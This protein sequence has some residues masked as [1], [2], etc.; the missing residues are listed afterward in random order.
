MILAFSMKNHLY[1]LSAITAIIAVTLLGVI[2]VRAQANTSQNI[3]MSP[4][5]T[6]ISVKAGESI[7]KSFQILNSGSDAYNIVTM[8]SPYRVTGLEYTPQFTQL[9]GTTETT[10]WVKVLDPV[11]AVGSQKS[12][13]ITYTVAVPEGTAP[14]GYYAVL[15]AE[16]RPDTSREDSGVVPRNRVGNIL[17]ITVEGNVQ[18]TGDVEVEP[19]GGFRYQASIPLG[20]KISNT[21][22]VHFQANV[23]ASVKSITGKELYHVTIER[24]VLPQTER[25]IPIEWAPSS[26]VGIYTVNRSANI[27]GKDQTFAEERII[28]IQP[29]V[30]VMALALLAATIL[31]F[32]SRAS[33]RR[34]NQPE[35][36]SKK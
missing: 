14:G 25:E 32:T 30:I 35:K 7:Q 11:V 31:Y 29:W 3:T 9:P 17:Y 4:A 20:F 6:L 28:Y 36:S 34:K 12:A 27:A 1:F 23:K 24:Y 5:S 2:T 19:V 22:G 26:P 15:F 21:G 18:T 10:S 33:S 13:D 8:V 16:T